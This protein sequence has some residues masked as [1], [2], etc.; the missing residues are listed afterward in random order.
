M[1]FGNIISEVE[2]I[3]EIPKRIGRRS[4]SDIISM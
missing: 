2:E 1:E 3:F 4:K